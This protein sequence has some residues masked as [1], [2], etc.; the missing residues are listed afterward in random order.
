LGTIK[1]KGTARGEDDVLLSSA[2]GFVNLQPAGVIDLSGSAP[3][4]GVVKPEQQVRVGDFSCG[5]QLCTSGDV[6]HPEPPDTSHHDAETAA[7]APGVGGV[8]FSWLQNYRR[9][10]T[11]YEYS[12]ENF[13]GMLRLA[14][15]LM[16]LGHLSDGF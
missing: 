4:G 14:S 5:R 7:G 12:L 9:V 2:N 3:G 13:T 16:L 6:I 15:A 1:A 8:K 10:V 11:R